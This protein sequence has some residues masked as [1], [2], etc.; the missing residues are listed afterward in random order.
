VDSNPGTYTSVVLAPDVPRQSPGTANPAVLELGAPGL[1]E[2][3]PAVAS[4]RVDGGYVEIPF[5]ASINTPQF[6]VLGWAHPEFDITETQGGVHLFRSV[7]TSRAT[8]GGANHGYVIYAG[9]NLANPADPV[10]YWQAWLGTG[11]GGDPFTMLIGSPVEADQTTF[12]AITYDGTT[13]QLFVNGST[14]TMGTPDVSQATAYSPNPS[15]STY[16]G[17]GGTEAT[18][19][20]PFKGRLQEFKYYNAAIPPST[21]DNNLWA[22]QTTP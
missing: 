8:D 14:D 11:V 10:I 16:I 9:P 18:Q 19:V 12:L 6:T 20:Y 22:G 7:V 17:M 15:K 21:I 3:F 4:T 2:A 1:L 5:S 13:A